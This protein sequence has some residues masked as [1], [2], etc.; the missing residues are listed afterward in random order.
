MPLGGSGLWGRGGLLAAS[1]RTL[2]GFESRPVS[3]GVFLMKIT[4]YEPC[5][6]TDTG[7]IG[8]WFQRARSDLRIL[9]DNL[10]MKLSE[11]ARKFQRAR[12]DLRI[13]KG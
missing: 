2:S 5:K 9:K 8:S 12:S 13:L 7:S 1:C 10:V 11:Y 3:L 4:M 6:P